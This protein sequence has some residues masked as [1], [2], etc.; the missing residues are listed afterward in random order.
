VVLDELSGLVL[1]H[2]GI[3]VGD[4]DAAVER[5]R[6]LGF[7]EP[8]WHEVTDQGVRVASFHA[9]PGHLEL[10]MPTVADSGVARY[11]ASRGDGIHHVAYGVPDLEST[12][13]RL[14]AAGFELI[15]RVPRRGIHGW[16]V[17]FVHPRSCNGVLTELVEVD[18]I[19]GD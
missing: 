6:W 13:R 2:V 3:V 8:Q 9:G 12:L 15:D 11:L 14:G 10:M 5:Y 7:G 1:H 18:P 4:L 17:A 16:R 19:E